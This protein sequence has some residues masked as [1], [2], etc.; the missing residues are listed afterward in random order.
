MQWDNFNNA[1]MLQISVESY[2]DRFGYVPAVILAGP[3][4]KARVKIKNNS[5]KTQLSVQPNRNHSSVPDHGLERRLRV[6]FF[7]IFKA[8]G[9]RKFSKP[10]LRTENL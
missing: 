8:F 2:K 4:R 7:L 1:T 10:Y 3:P 5:S 6:L 9:F